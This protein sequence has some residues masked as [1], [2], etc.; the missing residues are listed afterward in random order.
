V[1][2][3]AYLP[4]AAAEDNHG[5]TV[6]RPVEQEP[7]VVASSKRTAGKLVAAI[8]MIAFF[9]AAV[10]WA[11]LLSTNLE[12]S[13]TFYSRLEGPIVLFGIGVAIMVGLIQSPGG[14]P[15]SKRTGAWIALGLTAAVAV[16]T[17]FSYFQWRYSDLEVD[18]AGP[19]ENVTTEKA[20]QLTATVGGN[21]PFQGALEFTP[22]IVQAGKLGDCVVPATLN[23][24]LLADDVP[25]GKRVVRSGDRASLEIPAGTR[26]VVVE[27]EY[28]NRDSK[29]CLVKVSITDSTL[30][31]RII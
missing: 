20:H 7:D 10:L 21:P 26:R 2:A 30:V 17:G 5:G 16:V 19:I 28:I 24:T 1:T 4:E 23:L 11:M 27:V 31:R 6:H 22:N 15:L 25:R 9:G 13:S 14:S 12:R 3:A 18:F 8:I 29:E